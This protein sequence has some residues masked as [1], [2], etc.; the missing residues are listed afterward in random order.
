MTPL[1]PAGAGLR[2]PWGRYHRI[3]L[4]TAPALFVLLL[5]AAISTACAPAVSGSSVRQ[6][7]DISRGLLEVTPGTSVFLLVSHRLDELGFRDGDLEVVNFVSETATRTSGRAGSW[8]KLQPVRL[9]ARWRADLEAARF[10]KEAGQDATVQTVIRVDI[11][12]DAGL[13]PTEL[14]F[15]L[16][17]RR[18]SQS[19]S[20][21][22]RVR[23]GPG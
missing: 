19:V 1:L 21:P 9:P 11:P 12:A 18:S 15:T 4:R 17:G 10:V 5:L 22:L 13:G 7:Y 2:S 16:E 6:P 23:Y 14:R 20:V 3:M 8:L